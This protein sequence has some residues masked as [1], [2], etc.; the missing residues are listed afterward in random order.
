ME[1]LRV[2][3]CISRYLFVFGVA[4]VVLAPVAGQDKDKK[5]QLKRLEDEYRRFF[6]PPETAL[7]YW[8]AMRFEIGVGKFKLAA[9]DLKGFLEKKPTDEELLQIEEEQGMSAFLELLT[10][11]ELREDGKKLVDQ[12]SEVVKKRRADPERIRRFIKNLPASSEER[13]YAINE[14]KKSGPAAV[15]H[16]IDA[17]R[18]SESAL[19][20]ATILSAMLE[21]ESSIVPPVL[22]A[23]DAG[24]ANLRVELITLLHERGEKALVPYLW[25]LAESPSQ[26]EVVR[27]KARQVL[28]SFWNVLMK[29]AGR[30][31]PAM[32]SAK[33]ALTRE[34]ER[35][36]RHQVPLSSNLVWQWQDGKLVSQTLSASQA[37]EYFGLR[38]AGQALD[39]DPT[40]EP[41]Q[42]LFLSLALEKGLE[43]GRLDQPLDKGAPAVKLLSRI[44][45]PG[46][47]MTALEQAL[48]DRRLPVIL[49]AVRTLGDLGEVRAVQTSSQRE[50]ALLRALNYPDRRVQLA[51]A[52]ALLRIPGSGPY[53]SAA[54]L[55]EVLRRAVV[56][57]SAPKVIVADANAT[58]G[59]EVAR[60]VKAAGFETITKNTARDVLSELAKAADVEALVIVVDA[61]QHVLD[62]AMKGVN[63]DRARPQVVAPANPLLDALPFAGLPNLLA[64]L[65][66]D[67]DSGHLPVLIMVAPD[68][69]GKSDRDFELRLQ[70]LAG[71]YRYVWVMPVLTNPETLKKEIPARITEATGRPLSPEERKANAA[72]ALLWLKRLAVGEVPG[73]NVQPAEDA[74]LKAMQAPE[75]ASL[76]IEAAGRLAG[77]GAQRELARFIL[78]NAD[79]KVRALAAQELGR[80]IQ[81]FGLAIAREDIQA[82]ETAYR[83]A[84]DPNLKGNLALV[85]GSLHPDAK[86]T[87]DRLKL[88][89][90]TFEA[91]AK[92]K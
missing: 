3:R 10:I 77:Q 39:L 37:E 4:V 13:A 74:I 52:E 55:V 85:L 53:P 84:P 90:P 14:L 44:I 68:A 78:G 27:T 15:P 59:N 25:Y 2:V 72:T 49:G 92:E 64:Q 71:L 33:V 38:F 31:V 51:A 79:V 6:K 22:A 91:P 7:E 69:T 5:S 18:A 19:E 9:E 8:A 45:N 48:A 56:I 41:A 32:P 20:H 17:L 29:E 61:G 1:A 36:Y 58:R 88:Y 26:P 43:R 34:A 28:A 12:V 54:R 83:S 35:Y 16:L 40:Y 73:Y 70:R 23:L 81:Q 24:D 11:P 89:K 63:P 42:V 87:G 75:L 30:S 86:V 46:L 60:Q 57:D 76:A 47:V 66:A 67:V 21:L 50:P 80:N 82:L 62:P 65:R